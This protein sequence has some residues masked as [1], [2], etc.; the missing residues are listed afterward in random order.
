M[1]TCILENNYGKTRCSAELI[2][3]DDHN[4]NNM[5]LQ[6]PV[7]TTGIPQKSYCSEGKIFEFRVKLQG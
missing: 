3:F 1:Y 4:Y 2:V 7:F 5:N 6:P